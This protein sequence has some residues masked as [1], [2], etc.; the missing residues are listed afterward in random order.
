MIGT[1]LSHYRIVSQIGAG[2]MGEVFLAEDLSLGRSVALKLLPPEMQQDELARRRFLREARL[3]AAL[4]HPNICSIYEVGEVGGTDFIAMEYVEGRTLKERLAAGRLALKEALQ[5]AVEIA[6]AL[7]EAHGQGIVHRD[8]KPA[9]IMLGPRGR[10][11]VMDFGLAK[12]VKD[13]EKALSEE[14][15]L[16]VLTRA[17]STLGTLAY[18]SPEQLRGEA[19]DARSDLFSFGIVLYEMLAGVHPFRESSPMD[20][21]AGILTKEPAPLSTHVRECPPRM[22]ETVSRM[23]AKRA[24]DRGPGIAAVRAALSALLKQLEQPDAR[25][26]L[27]AALRRPALWVPALAV[28][29]AIAAGSAWTVKRWQHHRWVR[30]VA[31][32]E[33]RQLAEAGGLGQGAETVAAYRA[34]VALEKDLAGDPEFARILSQVSIETSIDTTPPGATVYAKSYEEPEAPWELLGTTPVSKHRVPFAPLRFKVE[35][36][37]YETLYRAAL[38]SKPR[39]GPFARDDCVVPGP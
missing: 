34:A 1:S 29:L 14:D 31:L 24:A 27:L 8:L 20:I 26:S 37:G 23:L 35:K 21:A 25:R 5:L 33:L 13:A 28:L 32:P 10:V 39:G 6:D 9:N 38:P 7:E 3:A 11:K 16:T 2:G 19:V 22:Q 12:L 15:T 30:E 18:M 36:P 17:G 4:N